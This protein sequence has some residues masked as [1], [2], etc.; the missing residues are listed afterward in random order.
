[1]IV[2]T[3]SLKRFYIDN[4]DEHYLNGVT[5]N[6]TSHG[7]VRLVRY[8][9]MHDGKPKYTQQ[10]LHRVVTGAPKGSQVDHINGDR[11]DNRKSNLRVCTN[12]Q[13]NWNKKK[14]IRNKSGYKGVYEN[15]A[16]KWIAQITVGGTTKHLGTF[17]TAQ[18]AGRAYDN[19]AM[20]IHGQYF[21]K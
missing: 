21:Y 16:G 9:G 8:W 10:Y 20:L 4:E 5:A 15:I 14:T 19:Y 3:K 12:T 7:Y 2:E 17:D 18:E 6:V 1:M 11:T 13:N